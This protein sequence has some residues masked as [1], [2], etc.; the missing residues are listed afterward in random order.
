[1]LTVAAEESAI[2]HGTVSV[3][4]GV[5]VDR[6]A[7]L[8]AVLQTRSAAKRALASLT[9][10]HITHTATQITTLTTTQAGM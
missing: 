1:M 9:M 3:E 6:A 10:H 8:F 5:A 4:A 7:L 2:K